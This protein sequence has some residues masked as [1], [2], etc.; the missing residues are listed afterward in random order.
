MFSFHGHTR[1]SKFLAIWEPAPVRGLEPTP[2]G[3]ALWTSTRNRELAG[4]LQPGAGCPSASMRGSARRGRSFCRRRS[5][6]ELPCLLVA[7]VCARVLFLTDTSVHWNHEPVVRGKHR[8]LLCGLTSSCPRRFNFYTV[9][10]VSSSCVSSGTWAVPPV[11]QHYQICLPVSCWY[12]TVS[13]SKVR[14]RASRAYCGAGNA[15][16]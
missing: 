6:A 16:R 11:P 12:F 3:S 4:R 14:L 5:L 10:A 9:I 13:L 1:L 15:G 7:R 2:G 8:L